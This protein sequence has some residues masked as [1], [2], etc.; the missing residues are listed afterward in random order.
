MA[1]VKKPP[2]GGN[3]G[4]MARRERALRGG[5]VDETD[6]LQIAIDLLRGTNESGAVFKPKRILET[7]VPNGQRVVRVPRRDPD[8]GIPL[9]DLEV[10]VPRQ[11]LTK[12]E[13]D[14]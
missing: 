5:G 9:P 8:T 11:R 13:W 3:G 1:A 7:T 12:L 10:T 14:D 2:G 6:F 4:N